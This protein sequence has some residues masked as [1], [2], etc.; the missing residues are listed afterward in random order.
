MSIARK[1]KQ[2]EEQY[3]NSFQGQNTRPDRKHMT[4]PTIIRSISSQMKLKW[5]SI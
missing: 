5:G 2:I 3:H 1:G 4:R